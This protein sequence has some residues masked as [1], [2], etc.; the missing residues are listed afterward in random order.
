MTKHGEWNL[1]LLLQGITPGQRGAQ[2]RGTPNRGTQTREFT[3][4]RAQQRTTPQRVMVV[5][6][7]MIA[8]ISNP[9]IIGVVSS[10][11]QKSIRILNEQESYDL[12]LFFYGQDPDKMPE[13]IYYGQ[14]ERD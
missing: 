6:Y 8:A 5:P 3:Q 13:I 11:T 7:N 4:R 9:Q 10:S 12:W 14:E 1:I 2:T